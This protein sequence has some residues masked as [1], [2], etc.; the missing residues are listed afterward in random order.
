M[1]AAQPLPWAT[2]TGSREPLIPQRNSESCIAVLSTTSCVTHLA[3]PKGFSNLL[4]GTPCMSPPLALKPFVLTQFLSADKCKLGLI[5]S[6]RWCWGWFYPFPMFEGVSSYSVSP[7]SST[8]RV[9]LT[10]VYCRS[11]NRAFESLTSLAPE[12][13]HV[14]RIARMTIFIFFRLPHGIRLCSEL[15]SLLTSLKT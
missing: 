8:Q 5:P 14:S 1:N 4:S 6:Q 7:S 12:W 13:R 15:T 3:T 2:A 10:T 11:S 9:L